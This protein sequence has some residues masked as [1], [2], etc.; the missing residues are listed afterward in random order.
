VQILKLASI[1]KIKLFENNQVLI[2]NDKTITEVVS[3]E[4]MDHQLDSFFVNVD[5]HISELK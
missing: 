4:D 1:L 3:A 5:A 2:E